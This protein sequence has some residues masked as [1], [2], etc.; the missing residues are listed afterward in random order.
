M[1]FLW[2]LAL[3][4]AAASAQSSTDS[5]AAPSASS[6][7]E[8]EYIVKRCLETE[9]AKVQDCKSNDWDCLCASYEAVATC[10][11]N[12]PDD[13]RASSAQSQVQVNCQ[14][15]SLYGT[16]TK[17]TKTSS[18]T[19]TA[20]ASDA[21]ATGSGAPDAT[22]SATESAAS[23]ENTNN[24]ADK[25]RNTAGVLLAVAGVVAAIL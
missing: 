24:A 9:N 5:G 1:K 6:E 23:A 7:C 3:F 17:A 10:F 4:A 20:D 18:S 16:A 11:N 13:P 15:A 12:C 2:S 14:Q 21:T 22:S 25:A 19:A 8:A